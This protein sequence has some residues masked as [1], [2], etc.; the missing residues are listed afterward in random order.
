M[1]GFGWVGKKFVI[2]LKK[3]VLDLIIVNEENYMWLRNKKNN[4]CK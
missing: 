4:K 1:V 2:F 3:K